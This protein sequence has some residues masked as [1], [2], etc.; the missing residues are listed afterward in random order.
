[1]PRVL[2]SIYGF[3]PVQLFFLH[4]RKY[5][6]LLVFWLILFATI[7][8]NFAAAFGASS[9]F[10]SPEYLGK[11]NYISM[12]LLGSSIAVFII[13][14]HITTFI[15][16]SH[17]I[18]YMGATRHAFLKYC[19]N[20]SLIPL[21]FLVFYTVICVKYQLKNEHE[22]TSAIIKN[23]LG[24]YGG[25]LFIVLMSF[26]YFFRVDRDLLKVVISNIANPARI[27]QLIPYDSLDIDI[28][29]LK[30]DT[31][32]TGKL[33]IEKC[34]ELHGYNP[35]LM[36]TVLRKHHRNAITA[37][38]FALAV[39]LVSGIFMDKPLFRIPAGSGFTLLFSI[40]MGSVGAVK[41]F[42]RSWEILGWIIIITLLSLLIKMNILDLRSKAYGL[43]YYT[44]AAQI[45]VYDYEHVREFFT[46]QVYEQDKKNEEQRLNIWKAKQVAAGDTLPPLIVLSISGGGSRAAY[47]TFRTL[48]Y[49][50]SITD[51]RISSNTVMLT[52]ASGGMI[53][54]A[55][56]RAIHQ[57]YN[58]KKIDQ[59]YAPEY[60]DNI[61]KDLL[62][63]IM[64]SF[65][66][67]DMISPINKIATAGYSYKKDRGYALEQEIIQNTNGLLDKTIG[68]YTVP[69]QNADIP[70]MIVNGTIIND[71]RRLLISAQPVSYLC[72]PAHSLYDIHPPI[73]GI[74]FNRYF[75]KQN[76]A[77]LRL[78]TALRM[79]A[80]FPFI[81]PVV[82]LPSVPEMNIM[83]AGLRDN[84]GT[85]VATRYLYVFRNWINANTRNVIQIQIRDTREDEVRKPKD[86]S[87]LVDMIADPLF[88]IQDKWE[89]FQS[90][91]QGYVKDIAPAFLD[92]RLKCITF[93][94]IPREKN[95]AAALNFHLTK[96]E[97]EDIY[98]SLFDAENKKSIDL[99]LT[100]LNTGS[101][102]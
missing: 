54:A 14:W 27:R 55:Y 11:V 34:D 71:G 47:W 2:R 16:H 41:Y 46:P 5:Q 98:N 80:T 102:R 67:V 26:S 15:I 8:G 48:Q 4:F 51:G 43:D 90:F 7:T 74:D 61:G 44:Q 31:Y 91:N 85:E 12:F 17:R 87:T 99:L 33:K 82:K 68:D 20:N 78:V 42:L 57:S 93:Q 62:N 60:Q 28:D 22:A 76:S 3:L 64:F 65:A 38:I 25:I 36:N 49:L 88:T 10:L 69:E 24:F 96:K 30:A 92:R 75:S 81:L 50:D 83:D 70:K 39:L 100:L 40:I 73:D 59:L 18:P 1:M 53:G 101:T 79:N 86:M 35:R 77:N 58:E 89:S 63:A 29:I 66:S 19:L 94:Y 23:Q 84:F 21:F 13:A 56:W 95:N 45:P 32:L 9:L 97:K 37:T 52:G 72:Q 6:L